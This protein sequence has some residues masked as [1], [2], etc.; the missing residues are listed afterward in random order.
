M[1]GRMSLLLMSKSTFTSKLVLMPDNAE[2][3]KNHQYHM[4]S[5]VLKNENMARQNGA[6][7]SRSA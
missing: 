5:I 2:K 7:N 3:K 4:G 1:N 6:L